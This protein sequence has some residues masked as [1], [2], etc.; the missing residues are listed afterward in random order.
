MWILKGGNGLYCCDRNE[1]ECDILWQIDSWELWWN[2]SIREREIHSISLATTLYIIQWSVVWSTYGKTELTGNRAIY[3]YVR[4]YHAQFR[5]QRIKQWM[6]KFN[7][8][9][10]SIT[11]VG[12][13]LMWWS[14]VSNKLSPIS[15][16]LYIAAVCMN[17]VESI[18]ENN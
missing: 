10:R 18:K 3:K 7:N 14:S 13:T 4:W 1:C 15:I 9:Q 12:C 5:F 17:A 6:N 8:S 11:T 16:L 2:C